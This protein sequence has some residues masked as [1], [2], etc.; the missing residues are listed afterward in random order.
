[1]SNVSHSTEVVCGAGAGRCRS[2]PWLPAT[3]V[4]LPIVAE[5]LPGGAFAS[6]GPLPLTTAQQ[7][8]QLSPAEAAQGYPVRLRGVVTFHE[9]DWF[10]SYVQ[11]ETAGVYVAARKGAHASVPL[12]AGALVE[13]EGI[14]TPGK[15]APWVDGREGSNAVIRVIGAAPMP[16]AKPLSRDP[17]KQP[18]L[19]SQRIEVQG[20]VRAI[21]KHRNRTALELDTAAGRIKALVPELSKG[22]PPPTHI[23]GANVRACGVFG[24]IYNQRR[25]LADMVLYVPFLADLETEQAAVTDPFTLPAQPIGSLLQ[26]RH[27]EHDLRAR[28]LG[29][30]TFHQPGRGFYLRDEHGSVWVQA[31]QTNALLPGTRLDVVGFPTAAE[32][33]PVLEDAILKELGRGPAPEPMPL[34]PREALDGERHAEL[35]SMQGKLLAKHHGP[36]EH[37]FTLQTDETVW[38]ARLP[39]GYAQA[40]AET[41]PLGSLLRVAGICLIKSS[42]IEVAGVAPLSFNL[43]A[44]SPQD[45]RVLRPASWWTVERVHRGLVLMLAVAALA[46]AWVAI[47]RRRVRAQTEIIRR[48]LE[49]ETVHEE[50]ARIARELHD[51]LQQELIGI[52]LQLDAVAVQLNG[53]S[54]PVRCSLHRARHMVR[55]SQDEARQSIWDLR[56]RALETGG[57]VRALKELLPPMAGRSP[58]RLEIQC[59]GRPRP[60]PRWFETN[61]LRI[62]QEATANALKHGVPGTVRVELEY[63]A[64]SVTLRVSD[65]GCG[66]NARE[67]ISIEAGH[68]GLLGMR[69]RAEKISARIELQSAPGAGTLVCVT[70]PMPPTAAKVTQRTG[71]L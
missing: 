2:R 70:A 12:S 6:T 29:V 50:R 23:I 3:L 20:V 30:V 60:L 19:H 28:V 59:Q 66:F 61:L 9:P 41:V 53:D 49:R 52:G 55:H 17:F 11:D 51:T 40:G 38:H 15:F 44:R 42:P 65:D 69:E 4:V 35:V 21:T 8:R 7:V 26:F 5:L 25:Q 58:A 37:V 36:E 64:E 68:F 45:V 67:S 32:F 27:D 63:A 13:V 46:A 16:Q 57:L 33:N 31:R 22:T 47:L 34:T 10:L 1:M 14:T 62:A 43:L 24:S 71:S 56:S 18:A 54:E 39:G 48:Q